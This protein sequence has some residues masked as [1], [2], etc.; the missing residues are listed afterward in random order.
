MGWSYS[1]HEF[2]CS[3][4]ILEVVID[5]PFVLLPICFFHIFKEPSFELE[6]KGIS[7][8]LLRVDGYVHRRGHAPAPVP[9]AL[10][11]VVPAPSPHPLPR[12]LMSPLLPA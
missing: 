8:L 6:E 10:P 7:V 2:A 1:V 12:P 9:P 5:D 3:C 11:T 4:W